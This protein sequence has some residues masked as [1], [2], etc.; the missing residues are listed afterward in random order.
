M[1]IRDRS[2]ETCQSEDWQA[3]GLADGTKGQDQKRFDTYLQ[4]CGK[5]NITPDRQ[6]WEKGRMEGLRLYCTPQNAFE[7]AQR[8][9]SI[10]NVCAAEDRLAMQPAFYDGRALYEIGEDLR[11]LNADLEAA[12]EILDTSPEDSP[13]AQEARR[14]IFFL[15]TD[16]RRLT[17][18]YDRLEAEYRAKYF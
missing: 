1:C 9:R 4:Q 3:R 13:R 2:E 11:E 5:F 16:I 12:K 15:R 10:R 6:A 17:W 14:E 18:K 8:G 7:L